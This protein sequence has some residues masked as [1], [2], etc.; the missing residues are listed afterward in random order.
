[1]KQMSLCQK[2]LHQDVAHEWDGRELVNNSVFGES[3]KRNAGY[4]VNEWFVKHH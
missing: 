3:N 4:D 1:M 2:T